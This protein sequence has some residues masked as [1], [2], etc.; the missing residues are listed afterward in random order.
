M[1]I[2]ETF[3]KLRDDLKTW[4]TNNLNQK[5]N[6]SYVD[7]KFAAVPE[8][9]PTE[10]QDAIDANATA[11]D[12]KVDKVD[13][14]GLS[15]NDYT[16]AEKDKLST[17]EANA[18]FYK[19]P[20]H[21]SRGSGLYKVAVDS[22]GHVSD[23][24]LASKEDIVALGI[25]AQ[26]TVYDDSNLKN[27]IESAENN[28]VD[29]N[30]ALDNASHQFEGYK[31][32]NDYAVAENATN[33]G[34]NR[35]EIKA[36]KDDYLTSAHEAQLQ[37]G[38]KQVSDKATENTKAIEKL[39]GEGEGSVKQS[40]NDAF[41]EFATNVTNN[42]VIDTYIELINYAA[43]HGPEFANLVGVVDGI[44]K[45]VG[46]VETDL[47]EY[48]EEVSEQFEEVDSTI[49][50]HVDN[51]EN[52]HGVNKEQIGL[53]NVDNTSDMDKPISNA[54]EEALQGK[55]DSEHMHEIGE[56]DS[57]QDLLDE[58]QAGID[59]NATNINKKADLEHEH[60]VEEVNGLQDL[61]DEVHVNIDAH[62]ENKSNPHAITA[63]QVGAY[64]IDEV[65]AK[66]A[67]LD[68][69]VDTNDEGVLI[70]NTNM[71]TDASEVLV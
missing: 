59:T 62:I 12:T 37:D 44:D 32:T 6:I 29:I 1:T 30:E 50:S 67:S 17:V 63:E 69:L 47:S 14:K 13:G 52:P 23:A 34:I 43:E 64:T 68:V 49:N 39:N 71:L 18:N 22:E 27:R 28:I 31:T 33:I 36:I 4:V 45:H 3:I 55:A 46:E 16:D 11:I 65:D 26:D 51:R 8:F 42:D 60:E 38:I 57:L 10:I 66:V 70:F 24:T 61:I 7:E 40:I 56:V 21:T 19:H 53:A 35:D 2:L 58:L 5:A 15:T 54:V 41:N 20:I 48:K 9:D 25:P